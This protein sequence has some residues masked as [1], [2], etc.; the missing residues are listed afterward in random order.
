MPDQT[1]GLVHRN[2]RVLRAPGDG[3]ALDCDLLVLAKVVR[4]AQSWH[5]RASLGSLIILCDQVVVVLVEL[6]DL[7]GSHLGLSLRLLGLGRRLRGLL[8]RGGRLELT[9]RDIQVG[10]GLDLGEFLPLL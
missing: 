10:V 7:V 1:S 3:T 8:H 5:A 6:L 4:V 9:G 2:Q